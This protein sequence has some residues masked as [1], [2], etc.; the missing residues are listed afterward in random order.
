[1]GNTPPNYNLDGKV[2]KTRALDNSQK[3]LDIWWKMPK[4]ATVHLNI[5]VHLKTI[6]L[7]R[8]TRVLTLN[9]ACASGNISGLASSRIHRHSY[10]S[11]QL[12]AAF[13]VS[14]RRYLLPTEKFFVFEFCETL[15]IDSKS[16]WHDPAVTFRVSSLAFVLPSY[17]YIFDIT[18]FES[19]S[20]TVFK[21]I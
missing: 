2:D 12:A 6:I 17:I 18:L 4:L 20:H 7:A 9:D 10:T 14:H 15:A 3:L 1:M 19:I 13:H 5:C 8:K 11:R 16:C 21:S